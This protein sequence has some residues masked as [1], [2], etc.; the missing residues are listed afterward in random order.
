MTRKKCLPKPGRDTY[1]KQILTKEQEE[2]LTKEQV[3]MLT[4]EQAEMLTKNLESGF[5]SLLTKD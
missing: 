3:E 2:M 4:K 1:H 5:A